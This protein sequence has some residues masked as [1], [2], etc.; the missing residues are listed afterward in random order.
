MKRS[1]WVAVCAIAIAVLAA[2]YYYTRDVEA[3]VP[4]FTTAVVSRG[5][6]ISTVDATG[7]LE[8]VTTVQVGSQISGTISA[9]HAD[10]NSEVRKGQIIAELDASLLDTQV[11]QAKATVVRLQADAD[12]AKVQAADAALKLKRAHELFDKQLIPATDLETAESTS[13]A[14]DAA[15]KGAEAQV[16][17]AQASLNQ[18]QVNLSHTIIRAPIDGV[19]IARNVDV[20]QT[21]ASSLQAPT[22]FVIARD[23]TEMRVNASVDES[24]IGEITPKQIVRFRVDAYPNDTFAGTVSQVRLQPVVQQNVV[25]YIT[26]IDVPNPGLKLKPGMTAAVTIETGR[27]ADVLKVPNAALQFKPAAAGGARTARAAGGGSAPRDDD[28]GAVWVLA[29]N[30]PTR[31]PVRIGISDGRDTA[32][33]DGDLSAGT[34]VITGAAATAAPAATPATSPLLPFNGRGGTGRRGGTR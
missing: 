25:S 30:L 6:V 14:A 20:G 26:V 22:L 10:F 28:R 33:L 32:V 34:S 5:D 3:E 23:L 9:L 7:T 2:T 12:R 18:A 13:H 17:Q 4:A 21:V 31:V 24:D 27:A 11:E 8:A 16:V 19:V 1:M 29:H 15:V